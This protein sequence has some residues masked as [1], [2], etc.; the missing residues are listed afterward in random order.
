MNPSLKEIRCSCGDEPISAVIEVVSAS[1]AR[2]V[3]SKCG[4][5]GR[6]NAI[7]EGAVEWRSL[8]SISPGESVNGLRVTFFA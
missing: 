3:P 7:P 5:C 2:L 4:H 6:Q 8:S 1:Q